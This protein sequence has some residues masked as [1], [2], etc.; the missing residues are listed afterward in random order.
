MRNAARSPA[1]TRTRAAASWLRDT[2]ASIPAVPPPSGLASIGRV[3]ASA[4]PP[5]LGDARGCVAYLGAAV[6]P[7]ETD[8]AR[9]DRDR[10]SYEVMCTP[11][12]GML[13][14]VDARNSLRRPADIRNPVPFRAILNEVARA[15]RRRC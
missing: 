5:W 10:G 8:R 2:S 7:D 6:I 15:T 12:A 9:S 1:A 3:A 4:R 14:R 13:D 11:G